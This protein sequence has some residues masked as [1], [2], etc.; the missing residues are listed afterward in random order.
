[1]TSLDY[2][3]IRP[4]YG[5]AEGIVVEEFVRAGDHTTVGLDSAGRLATDAGWWSS[6]SFSRHM[7]TDPELA[8]RVVPVTRGEAETAALALGGALP[9][10]AVLRGHFRERQLF[11]TA[12][13]LRLGPD[14]PP[15]GWHEQ[16]VYR[17]LFA[18]DLPAREL[19]GLITGHMRAGDDDF[20][21]RV[22]RI[23]RGLAWGLDLTVRLATGVDGTIG[24]VLRHLT[25]EMRRRGLI[26]VTTERFA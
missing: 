16:R 3:L 22:R 9:A 7:R 14:R 1:M 15:A 20:A 10:E 25:G 23:G 21:W 12:P 13:P 24:P 18:N 11:A 6:A 26:P 17:V 2:Y 5:S 8:A 4:G 19:A